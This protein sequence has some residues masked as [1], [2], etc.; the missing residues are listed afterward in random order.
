MPSPPLLDP[1]HDA[2]FLDFDGTMVELAQTPD[3][4]EVPAALGPLLERLS[5]R[6]GGRIAVISG[7]SLADLRAHLGSSGII[8][9]GSHGVELA[10]P[11][12]RQ[13][14][15]AVPEGLPAAR[16]ALRAFVGARPGLLIEDKPAGL[17]VHYRQAP[18]LEAE[19]RAEVAAVAAANGLAFGE[20][21]M[22]A[23]VRP[24]GFDKGDAMKRLM[25][26]P[27][28]AGARP[29]F[30]GD[31]ATDEDAFRAAAALGGAGV[32]VGPARPTAASWRLEGV[33]EVLAWLEASARG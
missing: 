13:L 8:L 16:E 3:A 12:G 30:V 14:S 17:A 25:T 7:R 22:V 2:L 15:V 18:D 10:C 23:E 5:E 1:L 26:E 24:L 9:S 33:A 27:P 29:W 21:K 19:V 28:Y 20:G 4:I 6:L 31:D 11:G 32:L